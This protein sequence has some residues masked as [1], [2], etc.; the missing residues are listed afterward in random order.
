MYIF[1]GW[2]SFTFK[3]NKNNILNEKNVQRKPFCYIFMINVVILAFVFFLCAQ[4]V[5]SDK[6]SGDNARLTYTM[7]AAQGFDEIFSVESNTGIIHSDYSFRGNQDFSFYV[8]ET[9]KK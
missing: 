6:D 9:I 7:K 1:F 4:V 8:S 2:L 5:A 3:T